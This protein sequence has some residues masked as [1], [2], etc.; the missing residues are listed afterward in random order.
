M[1]LEDEIPILVF[2]VLEAD[3]PQNS[4]I[5]DQNVYASKALDGSLNDGVAVLHAV[6]VGYCFSS[7]RLDL[8]DDRVCRL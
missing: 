1:Y 4:G 5:V 2:H 6:V 7:F 3:I 8:F